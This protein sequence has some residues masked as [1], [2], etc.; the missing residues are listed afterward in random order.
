MET[1]SMQTSPA[2]ESRDLVLAPGTYA[3]VQADNSGAVKTNVGPTVV[4]LSGQDRP[5]RYDPKARTFKRCGQDEAVCPNIW[6]GEGD[7]V[8]LENP[9]RDSDHPEEGGA[10]ATPQAGLDMGK[11]V[12]IPGPCTFALWPGQAA[13]TLRGHHLLSNQ[14]LVVRVYNEHAARE[15][16][17]KGVQTV[18]TEEPSTDAVDGDEKVAI[19]QTKGSSLTSI[20]PDELMLGQLLIIPGNE[21]SFYIP[22]TGVEVVRDRDNNY[23]RDAVTLERL[24]YCIL[25]DEDGEK[26]YERGPAV[27]FPAPTERFVTS[28]DNLRKFKAI[29][30]TKMAGLHIKV[31]AD[32]EDEDGQHVAGEELFITGKEQAIYFPR[33]EHSIIKYGEKE[34]HYA[35]AVPRGEGRYVMDR[36]TGRIETV[37]GP[38]MLMPDPRDKVIVRRI[39]SDKEVNLWYP[40]NA[41]AL[42]YNRTLAQEA[43]DEERTRGYV[44]EKGRSRRSRRSL[45]AYAAA[46]ERDVDEVDMASAQLMSDEFSRGTSF[47]PPRTVTL[48]TKY[49]GVPAI[50]VWTGYAVQV[51]NKEGE[52]RVVEGPS[53]ILLD[54]DESLEI[55]E[56]STGKP[57]NTDQLQRTVYLRTKNNKVS[58][59][60]EVETTD[61][62]KVKVKLSM[63][64]NFEGDPEKWFQVENYVKLLCDHVRSVLKGKV[65]KIG[66]E[67]FYEDHVSIIRDSILGDSVE[68]A[69]KG[70][71]FDENGM[72]VQDVE[73]L[74]FVIE[75]QQI[76]D[77][78]NRA[79]FDAVRSNI[80][81]E[82]AQRQ[83]AM[84]LKEED[85]HRRQND[86]A[87]ETKRHELDIQEELLGRESA[88]TLA[89]IS[90]EFQKATEQAKTNGAVE[91]ANKIGHEA[92][93]ARRKAEND[94][95]L[96][97][98]QA[99]ANLDIRKLEA[100]VDA[101]VKRFDAA[102]GSFS[103]ALVALNRDDVLVKVAKAASVQAMIGG[104]S[105][106]DV[107]S[108]IFKG[109]PLQDIGQ[110]LGEELREQ[111]H[112]RELVE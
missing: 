101:I 51:V 5:V 11:R 14:Y 74:G 37:K 28:P 67:E 16:W 96:A 66:I 65:K 52:R 36:N 75:D 19:R 23:V 82:N 64:V 8:I 86:A 106:A 85:I 88:L 71:Q 41:E 99:E 26:R 83:L 27:V 15:N 98:A 55:L 42:N 70:M 62:V 109:T 107:I 111:E 17:A 103:D 92:Q 38:Q 57:K 2:G 105:I 60:V 87:A 73:I 1:I 77:I 95:E 30:L 54:Y 68:G 7:Y 102:K 108:R 12:V 47:T 22:P 49:D 13:Q 31:I 90:A 3:Y 72:I 78:L 25:V 18:K 34:K 100:E 39:L 56:L 32:Y 58:D 69:R 79:Q 104:H 21:V 4:T 9:C 29:E 91:D 59:I 20:H 48:D 93:L 6:A 40:G 44:T 110:L 53:N 43:A 89:R 24:E 61:H 97:A 50:S 10:R 76:A 63:L 94:L 112:D 35:V 80:D 45:E 81:I 33:I 46:T 84:R